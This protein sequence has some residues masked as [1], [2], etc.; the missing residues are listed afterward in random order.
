LFLA[1]I[2]R[3]LTVEEVKKTPARLASE[4]LY[5]A[6]TASSSSKPNPKPLSVLQM[7]RDASFSQWNALD[8]IH[9]TLLTPV[10][11][12]YAPGSRLCA[13]FIIFSAYP[14]HYSHSLLFVVVRRRLSLPNS[15]NHRLQ[16]H[17]R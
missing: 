2:M 12:G 1:L 10:H 16:D 4:R 5:H 17:R 9:M 3:L 11:H 7:E 14:W 13:S 8:A 15:Q 6:Q